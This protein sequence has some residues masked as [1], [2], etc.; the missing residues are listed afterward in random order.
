MIVYI[1]YYSLYLL[2]IV[3]IVD[4]L[5]HLPADCCIVFVKYIQDNIK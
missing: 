4:M 1:F 5:Y 2:I 3:N